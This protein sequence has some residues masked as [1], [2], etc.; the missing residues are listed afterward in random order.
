MEDLY[1]E[2]DGRLTTDPSRFDRDREA[3]RSIGDKALPII[4]RRMELPDQT[5]TERIRMFISAKLGIFQEPGYADMGVRSR[6][7]SGYF[8]REVALHAFSALGTTAVGATPDLLKLL[9]HNQPVTRCCAIRALTTLGTNASLAVPALLSS[10]T[11]DP[12]AA[13]R[14]DAA[15]ALTYI[16]PATDVS[17]AALITGL[18]DPNSF[19]RSRCARAIGK[20]GPR[21]QRGI[22]ALTNLL[23]DPEERVR[24]AARE[25]LKELEPTLSNK[26]FAH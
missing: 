12:N 24:K 22:P 25:A 14:S 16:Q 15:V 3:I 6:K 2:V 23:S 18:S 9:E 21:A 17:L 11:N 5:R 7:R 19:T 10:L 26:T 4:L 1:G 8:R 20:L 13:V